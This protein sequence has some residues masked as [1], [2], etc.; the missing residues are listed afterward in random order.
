MYT[1]SHG[2]EV[3]IVGMYVDNL[4]IT[5]T[6]VEHQRVQATNRDR[7]CDDLPLVTHVLLRY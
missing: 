2:A 5:G 4:I 6:S 1:R 3:L 7:I